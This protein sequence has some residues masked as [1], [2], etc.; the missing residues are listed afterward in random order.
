MFSWIIAL[1]N[2]SPIATIAIYFVGGLIF[3]AISARDQNK[4]AQNDPSIKECDL[5]EFAFNMGLW[6]PIVFLLIGIPLME[7]AKKIARRIFRC[8]S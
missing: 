8:T 3:A 7:K 5:G 6:L 1:W 2:W 4:T